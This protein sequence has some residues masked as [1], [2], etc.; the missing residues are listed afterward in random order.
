MLCET[1]L[2]VMANYCLLFR[3]CF[4]NVLPLKRSLCLVWMT[5]RCIRTTILKHLGSSEMWLWAEFVWD[6]EQGSCFIGQWD[7]LSRC[8]EVTAE[9]RGAMNLLGRKR[10]L[11]SVFAAQE[12]GMSELCGE[13][14]VVSTWG[15]EMQ[16][17]EN[18]VWAGAGLPVL[19]SSLRQE[20]FSPIL[21]F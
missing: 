5:P 17:A 8:W 1:L 2:N 7:N 6:R 15:M 9:H 19:H 18:A 12:Q 3:I 21:L 13:F 4:V 10:G 16:V 14:P 20:H 11:E